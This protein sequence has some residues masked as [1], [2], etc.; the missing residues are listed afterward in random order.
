MPNRKHETRHFAFGDGT[1]AVGTSAVNDAGP[2]AIG[3][4]ERSR[5]IGNVL[6]HLG[7]SGRSSRSMESRV[8]EGAAALVR[9]RVKVATSWFQMTRV[10][11]TRDHVKNSLAGLWIVSPSLEERVQYSG[12]QISDQAI[13]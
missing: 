1:M 5:P 9:E 10:Y 3:D 2:I 13:S 8:T 12:P 4:A 6:D 7:S 11:E